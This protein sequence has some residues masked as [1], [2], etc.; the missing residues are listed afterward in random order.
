VKQGLNQGD[1]GMNL[2]GMDMQGQTK[3]FYYWSWNGIWI[4]GWAC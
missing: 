3:G 4:S 2:C 1:A